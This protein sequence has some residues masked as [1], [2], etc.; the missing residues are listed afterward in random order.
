[1]HLPLVVP[2]AVLLA[3][4]REGLHLVDSPHQVAMEVPLPEPIPSTPQSIVFAFEQRLN[5]VTCCF[6]VQTLVMVPC[7]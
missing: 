1:M 7:R 5:F 4:E 2:L 6:I 3:M